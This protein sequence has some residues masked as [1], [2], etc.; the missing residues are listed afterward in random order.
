MKDKNRWERPQ[1]VL[2]R[3]YDVP[4]AAS[5]HLYPDDLA[6]SLET[7]RQEF[8]GYGNSDF[9]EPAIS[10]SKQNENHLADFKYV[11]YQVVAGKPRLEGLPATNTDNDGEASTLQ[12]ILKDE[13][14]KA[15]LQLNY[16][17]FRDQPVIARSAS[18][19][20]EGAETLSIVRL[21]AA[22]IDFPDKDFSMVH[23]A[24]TWSRER[25]RKSVV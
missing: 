9:R 15:E 12:I 14:L 13:F 5:C 16:T 21:M 3:A 24:G 8:P 22:S 17:I 11:S 4:T 2:H 23:L 19:K 25:D 18:L 1:S 7:L 6:F 10:V 20:N